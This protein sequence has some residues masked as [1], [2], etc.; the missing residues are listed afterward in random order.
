MSKVA[1][2]WPACPT[3]NSPRDFRSIPFPFTE[4]DKGSAIEIYHGSHAKLETR[5]PIRTFVPYDIG[6]E[7]HVLAAYTCTPLVKIPVAQL[8]TGEKVKGTTIAELGNHNVPLDMIVYQKNGKEFILLAN[9][10]RGV[11]K[12]PTEGIDKAE[13]ITERVKDTAGL[14]YETIKALQ[15]TERLNVFDKGHALVLV[16]TPDKKLNLETVELP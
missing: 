8:K 15:G 2:S 10:Q 12:I 14:K 1:F 11:M 16:R 4:V 3:R 5:S 9:K 7:S 13:A 6:G